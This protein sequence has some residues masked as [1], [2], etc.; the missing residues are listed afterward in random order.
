MNKKSNISRNVWEQADPA[1][2]GGASAIETDNSDLSAKDSPFTPA[3]ERFLGKF[4]AYGSKHLG[5]IYSFSDIG[6]REFIA[7]SGKD[8][9]CTPAVLIKMLR[10]KII[11]IVPYTGWGRDDNYTLE[12]Q[13]SLDD[14]KGLGKDDKAKAEKGASG[15]GASAPGAPPAENAGV[16]KYGDIL[17][18][19]ILA[20]RKVLSEQ[21]R[22]KSKDTEVYV[23]Q[24]RVLNKIPKQYIKHLEQIIKMFDK[25]TKTT[26]E[27]Q[28]IIAD[29]L[30]NLAINFDLKPDQIKKSFDYFKNQKRLKKIY[31][32][33]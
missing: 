15:G 19:S 24:S 8:L 29:V 21:T 1:A 10:D 31:D 9:N 26:H 33:Q 5:I 28:R 30:D 4:D 12:L 7:R 25:K 22:K 6:I 3:E 18:E 13:L 17:T 27:K 23:K 11:K 14:V 32:N 16:V 2:A 20:T